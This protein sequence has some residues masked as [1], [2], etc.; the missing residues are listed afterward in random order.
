MTAKGIAKGI[1]VPL[2]NCPA[3]VRVPSRLPTPHEA[4]SRRKKP[5]K[6]TVIRVKRAKVR[7][8]DEDGQ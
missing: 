7:K 8:L 5:V 6:H 3:E 1:K 2:A 4:S